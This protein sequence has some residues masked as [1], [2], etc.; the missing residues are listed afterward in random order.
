MGSVILECETQDSRY[1]HKKSRSMAADRCRG[2]G[3]LADR[4]ECY[5][6]VEPV[7]MPQYRY[8]VITGYLAAS[9]PG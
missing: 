4:A 1:N 2:E 6:F 9:E 8:G 5:T 7:V 3:S